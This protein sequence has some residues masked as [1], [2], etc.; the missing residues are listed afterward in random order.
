MKNK[1]IKTRRWNLEDKELEVEIPEDAKLQ[2][3]K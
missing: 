2:D 3:E 1:S